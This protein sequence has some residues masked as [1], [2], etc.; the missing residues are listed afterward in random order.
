MTMEIVSVRSAM[1]QQVHMSSQSA[2]ASIVS[3]RRG[4]TK[5][6]NLLDVHDNSIRGIAGFL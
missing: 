5:G 1:R 2:R 4:S 3:R 6:I